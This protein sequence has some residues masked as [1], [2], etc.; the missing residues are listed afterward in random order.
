M[1]IRCVVDQKS[2]P[3][4]THVVVTSQFQEPSYA[5][6]RWNMF[7]TQ[8]G[9]KYPQL[10]FLATSY[11]SLAL[12]PPYHKSE[13]TSRTT[14][15]IGSL[16]SRCSVDYHQYQSPDWFT[17][18]AFMFDWDNY[19]RNGTQWCAYDLCLPLNRSHDGVHLVIGEF[20]VTSTNNSNALGTLDEGRLEFPTLQGASAEAAFM[21]GMERNSDVVFASAC[22]GTT[23]PRFHLN[24]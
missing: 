2:V 9:A 23:H 16:I 8:L 11:P 5:A 24:D 17:N 22:E 6:Y 4:A 7:V 20:A 18:A 1:R 3:S 14:F 12:D 21:T 13:F 15:H 19:P 10:E